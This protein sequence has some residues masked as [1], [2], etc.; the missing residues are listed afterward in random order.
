MRRYIAALLALMLMLS[1][2]ACAEA[3]MAELRNMR[4]TAG[5]R[6]LEM[7]VPPTPEPEVTPE[8]TPTPDVH[9]EPLAQGMKGDAVQAMQQRLIDLGYLKGKADG[10]YGGM[11]SAAVKAFQQATGLEPTGEADDETQRQLFWAVAPAQESAQ[12]LDYRAA[13]ADPDTYAGTLVQ[14][15]GS[16]L[17]V[18]E[19]DT[20]AETRGVYTVMRV[21]TRGEFDDVVYVTWFRPASAEP[22][23]E[24]D[25]VTVQGVA[26]GLYEYAN[27]AGDRI[28]LP[29]IEAEMVER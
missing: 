6:I 8:P 23:S 25:S 22:V 7:E 29:R 10:S 3:T 17:Q 5:D 27:E 1:G 12:K 28:V 2:A 19:D 16:V 24:G 9:Y 4:K 15:T 18:L 26:K 11:T 21:A 13:L 20:Y 14:L